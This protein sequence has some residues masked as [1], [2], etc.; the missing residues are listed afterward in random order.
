[1]IYDVLRWA[2]TVPSLTGYITCARRPTLKLRREIITLYVIITEVV[3][4]CGW[5]LREGTR[6]FQTCRP[7][8]VLLHVSGTT[9]H[10]F[11]ELG[12]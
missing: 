4:R 1:V 9:L 3:G 5:C 2:E 6:F 7:V 11:V 10:R 8:L 12:A